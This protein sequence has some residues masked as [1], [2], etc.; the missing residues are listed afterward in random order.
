MMQDAEGKIIRAVLYEGYSLYPYRPSS[1]KNRQR[2]NF[3]V[4]YPESWAARQTG[5]DRSFFRM[6]VLVR[7]DQSA[8]LDITL[9]FLHLASRQRNG[10][11]W[12]DADERVVTLERVRIGDLLVRSRARIFSFPYEQKEDRN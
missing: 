4:L 11:T 5:S 3:G 2:W 6:E 12:E 9:R 8:E 10:Q 7:G 1:I